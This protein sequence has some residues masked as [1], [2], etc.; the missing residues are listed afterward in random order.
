[1]RLLLLLPVS[2]TLASLDTHP[3]GAAQGVLAARYSLQAARNT[4]SMQKKVLSGELSKLP[5]FP[6]PD[7][8]PVDNNFE[9]DLLKVLQEFCSDSGLLFECK[10]SVKLLVE[11]YSTSVPVPELADSLEHVMKTVRLYMYLV[12]RRME[13]MDR[14]TRKQ[15]RRE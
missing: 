3:S 8:P 15:R 9:S 6:L 1:M 4:L 12:E 13:R 11:L 14:H 5:K 2:S 7:T 10:I